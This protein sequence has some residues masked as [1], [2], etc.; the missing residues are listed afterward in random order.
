[1]QSIRYLPAAAVSLMVYCAEV[2]IAVT[3]MAAPSNAVIAIRRS[4]LPDPTVLG[5]AGSFFKN[6]VVPKALAEKIKASYP[7]AVAYPA[8]DGLMKLAAGWLIV[9][10]AGGTVSGV[11]GGAPSG[12][13]VVAANALL[14]PQLLSLVGTE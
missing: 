11:G 1:M 7:Y 6:P 4:K 12:D 13:L 5:N 14:Q 9:T 3:P 2:G 10:G 8:G